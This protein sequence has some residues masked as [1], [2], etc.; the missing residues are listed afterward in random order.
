MIASKLK[1]LTRHYRSH[2]TVASIDRFAAL[3]LPRL[4]S[5]L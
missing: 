4:I 5:R 2:C 1:L 3:A